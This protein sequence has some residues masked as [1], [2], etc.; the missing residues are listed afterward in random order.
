VL[1]HFLENQNLVVLLPL[2]HW[3]LPVEL[4]VLAEG[5]G[6]P[7][8]EALDDSEVFEAEGGVFL[9]TGDAGTVGAVGAEGG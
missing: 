9:E 8:L 1:A 7:F 2:R 4:G 5:L 3:P 6:T